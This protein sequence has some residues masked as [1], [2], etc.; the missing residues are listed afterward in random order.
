ML[1]QP[2]QACQVP[3][4]RHCR[5]LLLILLPYECVSRGGS[6]EE[7]EEDVVD[8]GVDVLGEGL[9]EHGDEGLLDAGG[10]LGQGVAEEPGGDLVE[11]EW[12]ELRLEAHDVGEGYC[13]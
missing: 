9:V 5:H 4:P 7:T 1:Q 11:D 12:E 13:C 2:H 6:I 10:A 8:L 3:V